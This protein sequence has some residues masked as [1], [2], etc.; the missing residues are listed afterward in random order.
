MTTPETEPDSR[1]IHCYPFRA[2]VPVGARALCGHVREGAP[3]T[4]PEPGRKCAVCAAIA[5]SEG[6]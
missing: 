3:L 2:P 4:K 5:R 6:R 1:L